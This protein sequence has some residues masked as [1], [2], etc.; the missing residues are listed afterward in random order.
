MT[1]FVS[2]L[3]LDHYHLPHEFRDAT[4]EFNPVARTTS[5]FR[6][7]LA[8]PQLHSVWN[9][10]SSFSLSV[11]SSGLEAQTQYQQ[12][13]DVMVLKTLQGTRWR[14]LRTPADKSTLD[15]KTLCPSIAT[16]SG[17]ADEPNK[18]I[19]QVTVMSDSTSPSCGTDSSGAT[20]TMTG[21]WLTKPSEIRRG[22]VQL[23]ATW[24][25]G[26]T[27]YKGFIQAKKTYGRS[28]VLE[29]EMVGTILDSNEKVIGKFQ[30]DLIEIV[31]ASNEQSIMMG[32]TS[33]GP[34]LLTPK[35]NTP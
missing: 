15:K 28:G 12:M 29:A 33:S 13:G 19:V 7:H 4:N 18:G 20:T 26:S 16:F 24:K 27:I 21:R 22:A 10:D 34:I 32:G 14:I 35:A 17:F 6:E 5:S 8:P 30:A 31:E 11:V 9:I 25:I 2:S 3:Q 1:L 23:S